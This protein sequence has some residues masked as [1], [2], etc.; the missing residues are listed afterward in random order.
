[1]RR[2]VGLVLVLACAGVAFASPALVRWP[3]WLSIES[4]IN[5][6]DRANH[7]ALLLVHAS[8]REGVPAIADVTGTAEGMVNG[9]RR[10]V[11]LQFDTTPQPG[12]FA[13]RRQWPS[14]GAWVL[15]ISLHATT[16]I[17]VLGREG[18]VV[19]SWVPTVMQN[20]NPIPR[21]VAQRE[22]DSTLAEA[23]RR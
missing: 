13:L 14:N 18:T 20:G 10:S 7:G 12:V 11:K 22:I 23:A 6:F 5:P 3:P 21:A 15:S 19:S 1:M 2:V 9:A 16:A 17:V 8:T 4:P